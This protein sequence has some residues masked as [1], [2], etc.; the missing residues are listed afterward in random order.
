MRLCDAVLFLVFLSSQARRHE[1]GSG[2][3]NHWGGL[4][5]SILCCVT[6][7]T[8]YPTSDRRFHDDSYAMLRNI[9]SI[10]AYGVTDHF[11]RSRFDQHC[12]D[13][14]Q[15]EDCPKIT[16]FIFL[17]GVHM[18]KP[19]IIQQINTFLSKY[20][21]HSEEKSSLSFKTP[22]CPRH[23]HSQQDSKRCGKG[24]QHFMRMLELWKT[25]L[26][27]AEDVKAN[28][29]ISGF[30]FGDKGAKAAAKADLAR[31]KQQLESLW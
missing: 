7:S 10:G 4:D 30:F 24:L 27:D 6:A 1:E 25:A 14:L 17:A 8:D 23:L 28:S 20:H 15:L 11:N 2:T 31:V 16:H 21:F 26:Q 9:T 12:K 29:G 3:L 5:S 19:L 13:A 18:P 22:T